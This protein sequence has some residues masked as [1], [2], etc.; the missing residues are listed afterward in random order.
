MESLRNKVYRLIRKSERFF[1]A[2]MIYIA[3]S[4][5]WQGLGQVVNNA[6]SLVLLLVFAN[7]LPKETYGLYKYIL[8]LA[9]ILTI[10]TLT[11]MNQAVS[12]AV[13]TGNEGSLRASTNYQLKW[14]VLYFL[15]F[16]ALSGYY[17]YNGNIPIATALLIMGI[18]APLTQAF[19]TY[20]AYLEGK[21]EF[22]LNNFFSIISTAIYSAGMI[23]V[24]LLSG[25]I[26]WLV[27]A[28][29]LTTFSATLAFYIATLRKFKPPI[30]PSE[31]VFKYGRSLTY[32]GLV[33]PIIGQLDSIIL[34]HFWGP[35]Q[36]AVY[37][38]SMSIPSR[39]IP[40][41]KSWVNIAFPKIAA[42]EPR[43]MNDLFYQR[44]FQGMFVGG[45]ITLGYVLAAPFLFKL[46]LPQY[47]DSV[48]YSQ[49]LAISFIFVMP[50]RYVGVLLAAQKLPRLM[51]ISNSIQ[52][53]IRIILYI[54]LGI[55]GGIFG[56][57][58]AQIIGYINGLVINMVV[59]QLGRIRE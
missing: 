50:I 5:F 54:V 19:N 33:G 11:G 52:D 36:L 25:E 51:F 28:Y 10:F 43:N 17:F 55:W 46:L 8:S 26:V 47:M 48:F 27:V 22:Q 35:A 24:I 13:A 57:I 29:V 16:C 53:V 20:G 14:N 59:W 38:I 12:Q 30:T 21:R 7:Y 2:D 31:D 18:F 45:I 44:I 34:S 42:K 41:I 40:L 58:L 4:G 3:K 23:L 6:L 49:L 32:I 1:K 9:G 39:A 37:A 15:A 56:L